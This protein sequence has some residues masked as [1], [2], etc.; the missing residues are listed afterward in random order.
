MRGVSVVRAS[1][2]R[3]V[4]K[5]VDAWRYVLETCA[6]AEAEACLGAATAAN[7]NG[8]CDMDDETRLSGK[9]TVLRVVVVDEYDDESSPD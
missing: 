3:R 4:K 5:S 2:R 8:D 9:E 1:G 6:G 7:V